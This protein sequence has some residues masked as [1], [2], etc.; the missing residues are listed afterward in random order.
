MDY[1][2]ESSVGKPQHVSKLLVGN[3]TDAT[4]R[5]VSTEEG[6]KLAEELGA[7]FCETSAKKC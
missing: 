3:K 1:L 4:I 2:H 7:M 6:Q 5:A